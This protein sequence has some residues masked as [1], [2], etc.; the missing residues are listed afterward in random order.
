MN[1]PYI[2]IKK[3]ADRGDDLTS[4]LIKHVNMENSESILWMACYY[5]VTGKYNIAIELYKLAINNKNTCCLALNHLGHL[6]QYGLGVEKCV[7]T[8]NVL[9]ECSER[10]K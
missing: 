8:A 3:R 10:M 9:Y 6:H 4:D 7:E 1:N 2:D 5:D